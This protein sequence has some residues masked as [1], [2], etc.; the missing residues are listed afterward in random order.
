M[1]IAFVQIGLQAL[2]FVHIVTPNS[3]MYRI[4]SL[5]LSGGRWHHLQV[6]D[7]EN[8]IKIHINANNI[9][10]NRLTNI[11]LYTYCHSIHFKV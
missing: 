6:V 3:L 9:C 10:S 7:M 4:T 1:P 5:V 8:Y 2:N 11:K